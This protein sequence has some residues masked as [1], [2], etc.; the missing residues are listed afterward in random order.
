MYHPPPSTV[1]TSIYYELWNEDKNK[2][3]KTNRNLPT[4][5]VV[6]RNEKWNILWNFI[7]IAKKRSYYIKTL[8]STPPPLLHTHPDPISHYQMM[9]GFVLICI[10]SIWL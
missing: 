9:H 8:S 4:V 2:I 1:I 3:E 5:V 10:L 7:R 6:E